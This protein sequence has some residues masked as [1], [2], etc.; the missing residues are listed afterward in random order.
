LSAWTTGTAQAYQTGQDE[1]G[2]STSWPDDFWKPEWSWPSLL[3]SNIDFLDIDEIDSNT[4]SGIQSGDIVDLTSGTKA[5]S[6]AV[7][8]AIHNIGV[9]VTFVLQTR[10]GETLNLLTG[11]V[12]KNLHDLS[13][14]ERVW[15]SS[16]YLVD[17]THG[18]EPRLGKIYSECS[19]RTTNSGKI[20]PEPNEITEKLG[21]KRRIDLRSGYWLEHASTHLMSTWPNISE[22]FVGPR[23]IRPS[24]NRAAG[25]AYYLFAFGPRWRQ[26][27][28]ECE[29]ILEEI[30]NIDDRALMLTAWLEYL[31]DSNLTGRQIDIVIN[32]M[33]SVEFDSIAFD[34]TTGSVFVSECK[35]LPQ[36]RITGGMLSRIHSL[37]KMVFPTYGI[38][39]LIYSGPKSL[40]CD[41][42]HQISWLELSNPHILD[43]LPE[44]GAGG[45]S[46]R[47]NRKS[48]P[49]EENWEIL[50]ETLL[51]FKQDPRSYIQF[52]DIIQEQ[53]IETRGLLR[54]IE[55]NLSG[56]LGFTINRTGDVSVLS[57]V[58][59]L[60][61]NDDT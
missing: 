49:V 31:R 57:T 22:S 9:D 8:K 58:K 53:G 28:C 54:K 47:R 14:R 61:W 5:Q 24:F 10:S 32:A 4:F 29:E 21:L 48:G 23:L 50:K 56:E 35:D 25:V 33:H 59:W 7:I 2:R 27:E 43:N 60:I 11:D 19:K 6:G 13:F 41:G 15:L 44:A 17:Y 40:I 55:K 36:N 30:S 52:I 51:L 1:W 37:S 46:G 18:G 34:N 20:Q 38:P 45:K 12:R 39:L 3:Y 26:E 16:E 42:V